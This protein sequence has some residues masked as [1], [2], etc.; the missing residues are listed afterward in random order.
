MK[1]R[2][3]SMFYDFNSSVTYGRTD[4]RTDTPSYRD[5]RTHLKNQNAQNVKSENEAQILILG[6]RGRVH[7]YSQ[8]HPLAC[9]RTQIHT[10]AH[11]RTHERTACVAHTHLQWRHQNERDSGVAGRNLVWHDQSC[12]RGKC[13]DKIER[14]F[15]ASRNFSHKKIP[16]SDTCHDPGLYLVCGTDQPVMIYVSEYAIPRTIPAINL[17]TQTMT[18][19]PFVKKNLLKKEK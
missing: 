15:A 17:K 5:A 18:R 4:G 19:F 11:T 1:Q 13:R 2:K 16:L 14:A 12:L 9:I 3:K 6:A 10:L 8:I 7:T